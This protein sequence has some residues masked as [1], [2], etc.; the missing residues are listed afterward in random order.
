MKKLVSAAL[1]CAAIV[2]LLIGVMSMDAHPTHGAEDCSWGMVKCCY[3]KP[4]CG[5][6]CKKPKDDG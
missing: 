3:A 5:D 1:G 2:T 6:C 4:P